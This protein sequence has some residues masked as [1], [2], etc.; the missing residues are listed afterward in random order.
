M[1]ININKN[2]HIPLYFQIQ[3]YFRKKIE[4]ND[5]KPGTQLP[6]ERELSDELDVS[7][8]T[9][10]KAIRGLIAEGLCEKKVGKGIFVSDEKIP[11]NVHELE[12]TTNLLKKV[13]NEMKTIENEKNIIEVNKKFQNI[14]D[15][16]SNNKVL[17]LKRIRYID[18]SPVI[19]EHTYLPINKY[20][21]IQEYDFSNSLYEILERDYNIIPD[22][23]R[24]SFNILMAKEEEARLLNVQLNT[25]LLVKKA[26]V[27]SKKGQAIEYNRSVY[28]SDKFN[29]LVNSKLIE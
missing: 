4:K 15:L 24:G 11:I 13:A 19:L 6:T 29:F 20:P 18:N 1:D 9:I 10:R 21:N 27:F 14:F 17:Y 12:G 16:N 8:V 3:E 22:K 7:R 26:T 2:G 5:I 23:S 28:R 25:P